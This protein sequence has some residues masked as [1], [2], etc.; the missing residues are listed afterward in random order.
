MLPHGLFFRSKKSLLR[1]IK[2]LSFIYFHFIRQDQEKAILENPFFFFSKSCLHTTLQ[3][4]G[5]TRKNIE[6]PLCG[7]KKKLYNGDIVVRK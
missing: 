6:Y 3:V 2:L 4:I 1:G 5:T 7:F